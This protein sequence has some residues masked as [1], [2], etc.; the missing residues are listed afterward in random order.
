MANQLPSGRWRGRV[1]DPRTGKQVAPHTVIG[2]PA[3]YP[4][5][6]EAERAEDS[7]RDVLLDLALR[8]KT[9]G[10]FWTNGRPI[11]YGCA[12]PTQPTCTTRADQGVR[13]TYAERP[14]RAID[15]RRRGMAQ[16]RTQPR[17]RPRAAR[18]VQRARRPQAGMLI[19]QTRSPISDS[20]A[21][22]PQAHPASGARRGRAADRRRRRAHAAELRRVPV[23]RVLLGDAAGRARRAACGPISISRRTPR[24]SASTANGTSRRASSR[25]PST[26]QRHNRDGR[27][28]ARS[29]AR[30]P[31]RI[32]WVF[33]TLRGHHYVPST[34][35]PP[36]GPRPLLDRTR[37][38]LA[39]RCTRHYFAWY[40]LNVASF[41]ITSSR[42]NS[43]MTTAGRSSAS[44]TAIPTR[45]SPASASEP[46]SAGQRRSRRCPTAAKTG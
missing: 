4:T 34:R 25:T 45:R 20:S 28:A 23:Y 32:E 15:A 3:T 31:A 11:R 14:M 24:R 41:P 44:Y 22:G 27:A 1:R 16:G 2:G 18:D 5:Q 39:L 8:G 12:P 46:R 35:A 30:S 10:D 37:Q 9:V 6:R 42:S 13:D 36:L 26:A 17:N 19:D 38:Y 29:V 33:T 21:Q 43:A 40:L 7:A